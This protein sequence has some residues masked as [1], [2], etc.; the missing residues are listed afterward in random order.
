M[1]EVATNIRVLMVEDSELDAELVVDEI[2]REG[3]AIDT[4]R[5]DDEVE[6]IRALI[7]FAPDIIISDLSMPDFSGY[8]ALELARERVP[9]IPFLFVSGTMGEEAAVEAVRRGAT[10][11]V[12]K[13]NLARLA[14]SVRRAL[15]EA[16]E[17]SARSQACR[18]A[19]ASR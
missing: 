9:D 14:P 3:F 12:L 8:R 16:D 1:T 4:R 7:E 11:Y 13:H 19:A 5:V 15:R 17:R 10:D 2:V 18:W 6:F